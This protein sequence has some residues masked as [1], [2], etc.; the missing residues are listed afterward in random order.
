MVDDTI[1]ISEVGVQTKSM[2]T[3]LNIRT[4]LMNLQLGSEKCVR[5]LRVDAWS[6]EVNEDHNGRKISSDKYNGKELMKNVTEK[7]VFGR[8]CVKKYNNKKIP[9]TLNQ[10]VINH[11]EI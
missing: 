11:M 8:C 5:M 9:K 2:N 1:G 6:E 4:N 7:N 3:F 10:G